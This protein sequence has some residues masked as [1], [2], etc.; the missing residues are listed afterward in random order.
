[1]AGWENGSRL[2]EKRENNREK[3]GIFSQLP[4][5]STDAEKMVDDDE[6][7]PGIVL[8]FKR[9]ARAGWAGGTPPKEVSAAY[10]T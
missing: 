8:L 1:M 10:L 3:K 6:K 2:T 5:I 4:L 9:Q 7:L